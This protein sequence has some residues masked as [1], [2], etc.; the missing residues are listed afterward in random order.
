MIEKGV[1]RGGGGGGMEERI[2]KHIDS[3]R[4]AVD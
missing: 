2:R 1:G 3:E 4:E